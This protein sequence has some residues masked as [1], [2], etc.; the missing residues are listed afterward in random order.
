MLDRLAR[1]RDRKRHESV[2]ARLSTRWKT[3]RGESALLA[4]S[5]LLLQVGEEMRR[6]PLAEMGRLWVERDGESYRISLGSLRL[7]E[8]AFETPEGANE[9]IRELGERLGLRPQEYR[10]G[11]RI[12][13]HCKKSAAPQAHFCTGCGK[14]L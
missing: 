14:S 12:C 4:G 1:Q 8:E 13:A 7:F 10:A 6:L 3:G 5:D 9:T 2:L 11:R